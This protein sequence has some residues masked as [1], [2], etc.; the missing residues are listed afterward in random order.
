MQTRR[1][2]YLLL[3]F[4]S[5]HLLLIGQP[6]STRVSEDLEKL[7]D[8][9]VKIPDDTVRIRINDSILTIVESYVESDSVFDHRFSNV[10]YLGQIT[11]PD[12]IIKIVTWNLVLR[13][14]PGRYF[15]F[16]IRRK[17]DVTPP[18]IYRFDVE[19]NPQQI[20]TDTTY[21]S[22][23]WYGALYYDVR[24][25]TVNGLKCW[26]LLGIDYGNTL[27]TRKIIDILSFGQDDKIVLGM[28]IFLT[29]DTTRYRAVFEYSAAATMTLRFDGDES[30][31]FD[32][33]VPFSPELS[34]DRQYYGPNYS[35]DA[36]I[37]EDGF[38]RFKQNVEARN[39]EKKINQP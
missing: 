19:Y 16:I 1:N 10:R 4:I 12:S 9:L 11:S 24:P 21:S 13:N 31:I 29:G 22:G 18:L 6:V 28:N 2:A 5:S 27:I 39:R 38:W 17:P 36:F 15:C 3:I 8:R 30:I 23:D 26:V 34:N 35:N 7:Y 25:Q 14:K 20:K 32:H 37:M 33:L